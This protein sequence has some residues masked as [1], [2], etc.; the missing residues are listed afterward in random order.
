MGIFLY[1]QSGRRQK[2]E[3]DVVFLGGTYLNAPPPVVVCAARK[4]I[5]FFVFVFFCRPLNIKEK[6]LSNKSPFLL[7]KA[8]VV[9]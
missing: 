5:C 9:V 3:K 2:K 8:R 7:Y 6:I 4:C 1:I